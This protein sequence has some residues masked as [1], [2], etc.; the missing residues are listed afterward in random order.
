MAAVGEWKRR[1]LAGLSDIVVYQAEA[2]V[3]GRVH[4]ERGGERET[5]RQQREDDSKGGEQRRGKQFSSSGQTEGFLRLSLFNTR[6]MVE[7]DGA[8]QPSVGLAQGRVA[9]DDGESM[10]ARRMMHG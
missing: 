9:A 2:N 7:C 5:G 10:A 4:S 1:S 8:P 3:D 6:Y